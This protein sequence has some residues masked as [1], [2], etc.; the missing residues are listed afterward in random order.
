VDTIYRAR[1]SWTP[2]RTSRFRRGRDSMILG[3][4]EASGCEVRQGSSMS[5]SV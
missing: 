2:P 3:G 1:I 5:M 4:A